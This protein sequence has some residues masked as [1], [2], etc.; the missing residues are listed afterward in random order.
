MMFH[1]L[2]LDVKE[3]TLREARRVLK[4]GALFAMLDLRK[5]E[6]TVGR[7]L[8]GLFHSDHVLKDNSENR[9]L[10]LMAKA[11]LANVRTVDHGTLL[12]GSVAYYQG[13]RR[14]S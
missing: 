11:G 6:S 10:A 1:H 12:V 4:P 9:I 13:T 2:K 14:S 3:K 7:L 8:G 5:P